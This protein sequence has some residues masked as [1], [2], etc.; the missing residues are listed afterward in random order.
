MTTQSATVLITGASSGIGEALAWL[1]AEEGY[2]LV[3][4]AR[5][6]EKLNQLA[7]ALQKEFGVVAKVHAAD[8]SVEGSAAKLAA[9]LQ[10]SKTSVDIL[11]NNA[12]ILER[13]MFAEMPVAA[14]RG[15]VQLNIAGFT[16]MLA[17]FLPPMIERGSGRVLNVAS[18]SAFLP[19]PTLATYAATKAYVLS[20]SESLVEELRGTGV[21]LTALCPGFVATNMLENAQAQG[22]TRVPDLLVSDAKMVA[23]EAYRGCMKGTAVVVPGSL[24]LVTTLSARATPKWL[25]RRLTGLIGHLAP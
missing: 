1:F 22:Q 18:I 13:G 5:G 10:R 11:V 19:V 16:D 8:L 21:T 4:V 25:V 17:H 9:A 20:L 24:N 12:G 23:R 15:M 2:Q 3:L 6:E 7:A 14:H